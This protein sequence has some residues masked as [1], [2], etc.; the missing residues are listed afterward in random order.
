[1]GMIHVQRSFI[2]ALFCCITS[3]AAADD[4]AVDT[5]SWSFEFK[6]GRYHSDESGPGG[7]SEHFG[8]NRTDELAFALAHKVF[9]IFEVGV[10]VGRV[11]DKGVGDLSENQITGGTV[12]YDRYP[13]QAYVTVRGVFYEN[14]W[15]VPYIG[16]G[17][18]REYYEL[19]VVDQSSGSAKGHADGSHARAGVQFLLDRLSG[20]DAANMQRSYGIDNTYLFIEQQTIKAEVKS[21][22]VDIGGKVYLLGLLFEF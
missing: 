3:F 13:V 17:V 9:R 8:R 6:G 7:Y 12:N 11:H 5:P 22:K 4:S 20:S 16:G 10:E 19:D 1:M 21:T 18:T 14:Q 15:L 2:A